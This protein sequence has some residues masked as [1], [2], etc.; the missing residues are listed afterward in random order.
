MT[1]EF[2]RGPSI[3]EVDACQGWVQIAV[4]F[5]QAA[6]QS[7]NLGIYAKNV[8]GLHAF[9]HQGAEVSGEKS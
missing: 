5:A 9:I 1:I 2:R 3:K 7:P 6:R 4:G 8:E